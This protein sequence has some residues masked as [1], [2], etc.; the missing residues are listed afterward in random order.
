MTREDA[1][2]NIKEHCYFA[3]LNPQAKEALDMAIKVLEQ[4]PSV[5]HVSKKRENPDWEIT[6][7]SGAQGNTIDRKIKENERGHW[8]IYG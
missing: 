4:K 8:G 2:K 7:W 3:N 1:I 5:I 6:D